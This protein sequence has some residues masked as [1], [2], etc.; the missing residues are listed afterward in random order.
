MMPGYNSL[1]K[2][3]RTRITCRRHEELGIGRNSMVQSMTALCTSK[4]W[5]DDSTTL[6]TDWD[7]GSMAPFLY[8][9]ISMS[10][11]SVKYKCDFQGPVTSIFSHLCKWKTLHED[12]TWEDK[13]CF[14]PL[15]CVEKRERG[16]KK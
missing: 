6:S 12:H 2:Y 8:V 4:E 15:R 14:L 11:T 16:G 7:T 10:Y 3:S 1:K 9:S 13:H 5:W